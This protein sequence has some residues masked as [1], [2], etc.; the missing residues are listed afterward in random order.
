MGH[1]KLPLEPKFWVAAH[2][3]ALIQLF[4]TSTI[5]LSLPWAM[6]SKGFTEE[7][8]NDAGLVN[9]VQHIAVCKKTYEAAL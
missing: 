4:P 6:Q 1:K 2:L 7:E 9:R 3:Y 5:K 8:S